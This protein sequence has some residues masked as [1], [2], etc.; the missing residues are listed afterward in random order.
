MTMDWIPVAG[1]WVT[2][3][4][5]RYTADAAANGWYA[6]HN[7]YHDRFERG[8]AE[9][10]GVAHATSLPSCTSALHLALT[11]LGIGPGDEVIVPDATWIATSAPVSYVGATPVFADVDK[12]SWC[13]D[14]TA[15]EQAIT[16]RTKA[17]IVVHLYGNMPDMDA[18]MEVAKQH[19][20]AVIEDAAEAI[21]SEFR[22]RKAGAFGDAAAFSF[23]GSKT[24]T[25]GEGGMLVT[26]RDD[27]FA[28]VLRLRD[29][30]REPGDLLFVNQEI[31]FKYKMSALQAAFGLAQLERI[32]ELVARK[33]EIFSCYNLHLNG[34]N[35]IALNN[36]APTTKNTYWMVTAVFDRELGLR[37][38]DVIAELRRRN[39]DSRPFF[40]PL[41]SLPAYRHFGGAAAWNSCN[42]TSYDI[43]LRGVNLPS[44][45]NMTEALVERVVDAIYDITS[46]RRFGSAVKE[47]L[48]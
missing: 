44:G 16:P 11:A 2:E 40:S 3:K 46:A 27:L 30:G 29:H 7:V 15:L 10:L 31:A 43:G 20:I 18:I 17:V 34:I 23:H 21:G 4:E 19:G 41:S 13:L 1:P 8:F 37:K 36:E 9:Y 39:I 6:T 42:P 47:S 5:V 26:S 25:T 33:R 48:P 14:G 32:E 12:D 45:F 24:L 35:G 38:E 28:R 22:G